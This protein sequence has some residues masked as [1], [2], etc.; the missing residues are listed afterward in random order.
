MLI[1]KGDINRYFTVRLT[2]GVDPPPAPPPNGQLFMIF[3][4]VCLNPDM[5]I[6]VLKR[7]SHKKRP[8]PLDM[9]CKRQARPYDHLQEAG[10]FG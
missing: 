1:Y 9:I 3:L 2:E 4:V 7:I 6:C 10:P 5:H 8:A